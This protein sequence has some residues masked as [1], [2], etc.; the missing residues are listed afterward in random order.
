MAATTDE[1][2]SRV[3]EVAGSVET[4]SGQSQ[5]INQ[6]SSRVVEQARDTEISLK[7][8]IKKIEDAFKIMGNIGD[9][10]S[11]SMFLEMIGPSLSF[12]LLVF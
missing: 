2:A 12:I 10:S 4:L 1:T 7:D 6:I 11:V 9:G 5:S 3:T 8:S